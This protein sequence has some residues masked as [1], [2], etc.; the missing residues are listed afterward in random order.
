MLHHGLGNSS[1]VRTISSSLSVSLSG[2]MLWVLTRILRYRFAKLVY[3]PEGK[4]VMD[5]VWEETLAEFQFAGAREILEAFRKASDR[6]SSGERN[7]CN[8][9]GF[10]VSFYRHP[11]TCCWLCS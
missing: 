2:H 10:T 8:T 5:V 4:E 7:R 6:N 11:A 1:V 9:Q 3:L